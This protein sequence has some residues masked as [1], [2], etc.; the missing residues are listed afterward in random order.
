MFSLD[1]KA[2]KEGFFDREK[3]M[4]AMDKA[5]IGAL[6]KFGAFVRQRAKSSI[7]KRK[8]SS[9]PG[10]APSSHVGLLKN[11]IFFSYDATAKSVVIGPTLI[12]KPTGAP[13]TLEY[14]GEA[15]IEGHQFRTRAGKR[16]YEKT[17]KR[18]SIAPRPY[19]GPAFETEKTKAA[20][21]WK[22]SIR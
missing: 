3:V 20:E 1:F 11:L 2:A 15:E 8:K 7:R 10:Q 19:M 6:S 21:L 17:S 4:A 16:V 13:A 9:K 22:N 12:N 14:G 18:V 5:T